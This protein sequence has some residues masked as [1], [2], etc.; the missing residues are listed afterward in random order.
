M[1]FFFRSRQFKKILLIATII[2]AFGIICGLIGL[3]STPG[4]SVFGA[5]VRP[6][7]NVFNSV[8]H[9]VSDFFTKLNEG[10]KLLDDVEVLKNENEELKNKLVNY[11]QALQ[12]NR[13]YKDFLELK[14]NNTDFKFEDAT[15]ISR[16]TADIY[17]CFTID[18]GLIDGVAVGDPVITSAGL[19]GY[20]TET[21]QS[22]SKV[23]TVLDPSINVAA[24]DSRT[25]DS[26]IVSGMPELAVDGKF[27]MYNLARSC[28]V[29]VGDYVITSGGG[30]FPS[31][32]IIGT[33]NDIKADKMNTSLYAVV[34]PIV[35]IESIRDVMVI[36]YFSGQ[37]STY[38]GGK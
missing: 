24:I 6:F 13:F 31:G 11:E 4:S 15:V 33:V 17:G 18:A 7:Q 29:T 14:E 10:D 5:V 34:E 23:T 30:V 8:S 35:D 12:E 3:T 2:V 37:G 19:V 26:G 25:D 20:V 1:R 36:T 22:F 21:A 16:D 28:S 27:R 32:L 9:G 38:S